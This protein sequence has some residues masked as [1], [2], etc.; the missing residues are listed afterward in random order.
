MEIREKDGIHIEGNIVADARNTSGEVNFVSHAHYDHMPSEGSGVVASRV[1]AALAEER[2]GEQIRAVD[3]EDVEKLESGHIVG[4]R[5]ALFDV[6]GKKVLYTADFS[7]RDRLY[8]DGFQPREADVL[9]IESTYGVPAYTFASQREVEKRFRDWMEKNSNRPV[10][11]FGYSLGKAQK[12]QYLARKYSEREIVA[13]GAVERM[14]EAVERVTELEFDAQS[15][16]DNK[17][18]LEEGNAVFVGPTSFAGTEGLKKLVKKT[19]GVTAG[20]SGW[21]VNDRYLYRGGY[22]TGFV[23]SD[24]ADFQELVETCLEVD[25]ERIYTTHGFTDALASHLKREH[26]FDARAL[27]NNQTSLSDF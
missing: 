15:Y 17:Q 18:K 9:I 27:K 1:T 13:H 2:S 16:A 11:L 12:I 10:F 4:S 21:A 3:H 19:G 14:N 7:P 5:S 25:P 23:L 6:D 26:G 22:D 24:H 8:M 20:F